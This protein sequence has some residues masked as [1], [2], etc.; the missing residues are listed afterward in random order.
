MKHRPQQ[1]LRTGQ[2]LGHAAGGF[3]AVVLPVAHDVFDHAEPEEQQQG[4]RDERHGFSEKGVF[5][6]V[7][8]RRVV[9]EGQSRLRV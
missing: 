3:A 4:D 8:L 6:E 1:R 5:Q 9:M 7:L 2:A